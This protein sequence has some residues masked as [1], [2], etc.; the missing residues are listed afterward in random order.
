MS[1]GGFD[2]YDRRSGDDSYGGSRYGSGSDRGYGGSDRGYGGSDRGYGGGYGGGKGGDRMGGLGGDLRSVDWNRQQ[3]IPFEKNFYQMHPAVANRHPAEIE[4]FLASQEITTMGRDVPRPVMNFEEACFPPYVM[5][6]IRMQGYERPSAIQCMA[7]PTALS[8]RDMIG[9]AATGSGKTAG[10]L[11]PGIVHTNAQPQLQRGDGP[12]I[13]V[14]APTRELAVQIQG[15]VQKFGQSSRIRSTCVYGGA[16]KHGQLRDLREG[17]EICIATPGRLIDFLGRNDTNLRRVTYLVLD[18]ADRM[19]DMGFEPQIRK[20]V[21]QI[22]PDRQ[23]CFWS[24]TWPKNVERL[25]RDL[26][27]DDPVQINVGASAGGKLK[28]NPNITQF[29]EVV[30][31]YEKEQRIL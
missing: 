21:A 14:L 18:E 1:F 4:Q 31:E 28:A 22:R 25:A 9:V 12:I 17:V 23:T 8:G 29:V 13:L 11:L 15:E 2:S 3:L 24:A 16:P 26:C 20:I 5:E 10:F 27:K 7:W 6:A 19:L 30:Q